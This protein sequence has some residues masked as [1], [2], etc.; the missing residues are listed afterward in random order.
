MELHKKYLGQI[1]AFSILNGLL[2]GYVYGVVAG[3]IPLLE[4]TVLVTKFQISLFAGAFALGCF[5]A[6]F[7]TGILNDLWGRKKVLIIT[8]VFFIVGLFMFIFSDSFVSIYTSRTLQCIGFGMATVVVPM[9]LTEISPNAKRGKIMICF[10]LS[11]GG[12]IL[13]SSLINLWLLPAMNWHY[14][15]YVLNIVPMLLIVMTL[16]LPE[17]PRWFVIK[18]NFDKAKEVLIMLNSAEDAQREFKEMQSKPTTKD[19]P[20]TDWKAV[21]ERRYMVPILLV[22]AAVSLNQLFGMPVF[23]Q[24]SVKILQDSGIESVVIGLIGGVSITGINFIAAIL[25]MFLVEKIGR[26]KILK[27]GT[28]ALTISLV[29][30]AM[31]NFFM[32]ANLMKGYLT[33]IGIVVTVGLF[34]FGPGGVILLLCTELLP[35]K[36]RGVGITIAFVVGATISL[37]FVCLFLPLTDYIGY[38]G[39][40]L[41]IGFFMLCYFVLAFAIPETKG[42]TL[43]E[44]EKVFEKQS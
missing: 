18:G 24:C 42:K 41:L 1:V 35:N 17:S 43:E 38:G 7:Y 26:M 28:L 22:T 8:L 21:L 2:C 34:G 11:M 25:T 10:Q 31:I 9:Y 3:I 37:F 19:K 33:L 30:L 36:V 32:P 15:F 12:G 5:V 40:F 4:K 13:L 16:I 20:K 29:T 27:I 23:I 6:S 39:L 44:I 14:L